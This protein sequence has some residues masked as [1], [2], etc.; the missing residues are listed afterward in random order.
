M[1]SVTRN[2]PRM[3]YRYFVLFCESG[4]PISEEFD[5]TGAPPCSAYPSDDGPVGLLNG[6]KPVYVESVTD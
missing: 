1:L 3:M 2:M 4:Q 5:I 6:R